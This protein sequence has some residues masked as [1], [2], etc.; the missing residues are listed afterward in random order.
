MNTVRSSPQFVKNMEGRTQPSGS[1]FGYLMVAVMAIFLIG[2][3]AYGFALATGL[4]PLIGLTVAT[5]AFV[6]R[7]YMIRRRSPYERVTSDGLERALFYLPAAILSTGLSAFA[8]YCLVV[9]GGADPKRR[10]DGRKMEHAAM[11]LENYYHEVRA[12]IRSRLKAIDE[13]LRELDNQT[14]SE[15]IRTEIAVLEEERQTLNDLFRQTAIVFRLPSSNDGDR[16]AWPNDD[17]SVQ[18][19]MNRRF[20][21]A[22]KLHRQLPDIISQEVKP[23]ML[24]SPPENAISGGQPQRFFRSVMALTNEAMGCLA[25]PIILEI[26]IVLV[27]VSNRPHE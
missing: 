27:V 25:A 26:F 4:P 18:E 1:G 2:A 21:E 13:R 24:E 5:L 3:S 8:I 23:P 9:D 22:A 14:P 11:A 17:D 15:Q 19:D 20:D 16:G 10:T 12:Q 6:I 7:M